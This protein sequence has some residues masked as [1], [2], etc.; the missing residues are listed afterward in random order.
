MNTCKY[1]LKCF[2]DLFG[3]AINTFLKYLYGILSTI[4]LHV[5][6]HYDNILELVHAGPN[7][8]F[9]LPYVNKLCSF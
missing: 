7:L 4:I 2:I 9:K 3:N 8:F 1:C 6:N 5:Y